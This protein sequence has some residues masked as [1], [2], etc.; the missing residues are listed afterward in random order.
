[1][2]GAVDYNLLKLIMKILFG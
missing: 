1:M 2:P